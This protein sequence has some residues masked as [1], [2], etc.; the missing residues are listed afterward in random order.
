M[1]ERN[2]K[3][4]QM[5]LLTFSESRI[6]GP[7]SNSYMCSNWEL[8]SLIA[9]AAATTKSAPHR[10]NM[11]T[12]IWG[13]RRKYRTSVTK[14]KTSRESD[15][16]QRRCKQ[17]PSTRLLSHEELCEELPN[18]YRSYVASQPL[19]PDYLSKQWRCHSRVFA[20]SLI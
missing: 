14:P 15:Q 13:G 20:S 10:G 1:D 7:R 18:E 6:K 17:W 8:R 19:L 9:S 11:I 2:P 12:L 16:N 5:P 3:A 4:P